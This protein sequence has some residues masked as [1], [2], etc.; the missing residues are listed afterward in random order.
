MRYLNDPLNGDIA[1]H[2]RLLFPG[3]HPFGLSLMVEL[4]FRLRHIAQKLEQ[5]SLR[6]EGTKRALLLFADTGA[7]DNIRAR[8]QNHRLSRWF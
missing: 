1:A 6:A 7:Y 3:G 2:S 8:S 5:S 4:L